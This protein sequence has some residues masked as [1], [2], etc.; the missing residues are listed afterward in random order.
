MAHEN[1]L[2][3]ST[4]N[5]NGN[6]SRMADEAAVI[7]RARKYVAKLPPSVSG[8]GGHNAAFHAACSLVLG[9]RLPRAPP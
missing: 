3:R 1:L 2:R 4:R 8:S 9:F 5:V 7:K 6:Q